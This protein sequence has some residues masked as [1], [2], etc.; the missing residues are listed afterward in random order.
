[1]KKNK[2]MRIAS[3]VMV[4]ALLSTCAISGTFAKYTSASTGS[5]N[6]RVARWDIKLND[7]AI[8]NS[9]EFNLFETIYDTDAKT[10]ET[11]VA[12]GLIAPGT[13]GAFEIKL[14]SA[15]EVSAKY[16]VDYTV[17]NT[18]NI[19]VQFSVDGTKWTDDL[20]DVTEKE[21][22]MT[23]GTAS[24][25]VQWKWVFNGNDATDTELGTAEEAPTIT[26]KAV[27]T[28]EQVD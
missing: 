4:A 10:V 27:V 24:I 2:T 20:A 26:V 5:D 17:K 21:L 16:S 3:V 18:N 7:K 19:P 1:M 28:V 23:N 15:S 12:T 14:A 22:E 11:D 13:S 9:F 6:A 25:T 8:S